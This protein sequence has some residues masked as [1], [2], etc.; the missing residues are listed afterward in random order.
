MRMGRIKKRILYSWNAD[1]TLVRGLIRHESGR[2]P[3]SARLVMHYPQSS[4]FSGSV[5]PSGT[6]AEV[7]RLDP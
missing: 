2:D 6:R 4:S 1:G 7:M 5:M 3:K